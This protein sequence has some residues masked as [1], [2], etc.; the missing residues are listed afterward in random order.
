MILRLAVSQEPAS[1]ARDV[2]LG[3]TFDR[4]GCDA[5]SMLAAMKL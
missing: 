4:I 3:S 2:L 5:G 1:R